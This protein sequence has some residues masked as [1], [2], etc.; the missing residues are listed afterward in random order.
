MKFAD[1]FKPLELD[2]HGVRL[3]SFNIEDKYKRDLGVSEDISNENFLKALCEEGMQLVSENIH[4]KNKS[5][6]K[7]RLNR[8]FKTIK[9]LGFIDTFYV[10][11]M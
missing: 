5:A 2:L 11:G 3:P 7:K 8:E 10:F 1:Q 9:E 6:Y 4:E